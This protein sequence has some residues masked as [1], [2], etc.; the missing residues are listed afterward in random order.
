MEDWERRRKY[1]HDNEIQKIVGKLPQRVIN[2]IARGYMRGLIEGPL[3]NIEDSQF[4]YIYGV[5][6]TTLAQ[7]RKV[8]PVPETK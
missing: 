5:G 3:E 2:L 1:F 6:D 7:I 8:F 4:M